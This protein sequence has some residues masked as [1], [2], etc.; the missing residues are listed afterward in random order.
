M[1]TL[2]GFPTDDLAEILKNGSILPMKISATG[3]ADEP[4]LE[5]LVCTAIGGKIENGMPH[6]I[7]LLRVV[8]GGKATRESYLH[9]Y[10]NSHF[11]PLGDAPSLQCQALYDACRRHENFKIA[12]LRVAATIFQETKASPDLLTFCADLDDKN[13]PIY[14]AFILS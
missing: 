14:S 1:D 7:E 13:E 4:I 8:E 6:K 2:S 3:A 11:L 5:V 9:E 10:P 12:L